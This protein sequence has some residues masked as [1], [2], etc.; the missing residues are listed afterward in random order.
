[1]QVCVTQKN[2]R[3]SRGTQIKSAIGVIIFFSAIIVLLACLI[4]S[5]KKENLYT[6]KDLFFVC[7][8]KSKNPSSLEVEKELVQNLG[9]AGVLFLNNR[10][11]YLIVNVYFEKDHAEEVKDKIKK[12]FPN[13]SVLKI[14]LTKL[15]NAKY[16][17]NNEN[18][19]T[20]LKLLSTK[21]EDLAKL[22]I[23]Y[24]SGKVSD[25]KCGSKVLLAKQE[26]EKQTSEVLSET[27]DISRNLCSYAKLISLQYDKFLDDFYIKSNKQALVCEFLVNFAIIYADMWNNL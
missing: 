2:V 24:I 21:F 5:R 8:N 27:V 9:G 13:A 6:G 12:D 17:R 18:A 19:K 10:E 7:T 20:L 23:D 14:S 22:E 3:V 25:G 4:V 15:K 16:F 11:F 1:M 26:I